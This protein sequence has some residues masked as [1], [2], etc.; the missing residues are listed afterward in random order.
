M[1]NLHPHKCKFSDFKMDSGEKLH[2]GEKY[3]NVQWKKCKNAQWRKVKKCNQVGE[4]G[5]RPVYQNN[6]TKEFLFFRWNHSSKARSLLILVPDPFSLNLDPWSW[7]F[8]PWSL[9]PDL[10]CIDSWSSMPSEKGA[11]WLV[12]PDFTSSH[13]GVQIF[14]NDDKQCP[15]RF[16]IVDR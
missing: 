9:I 13:G 12:G 16:V 7:S 4:Q 11:E 3:K 15:E 5:G 8:M 6:A 1:T 14:G 2:S 10:L